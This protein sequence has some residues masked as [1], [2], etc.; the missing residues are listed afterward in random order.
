MAYLLTRA[1]LLQ[2]LRDMIKYVAASGAGSSAEL[3]RRLQYQVSQVWERMVSTA[4]GVGRATLSKTIAVADPDGYVPGDFVP[5]PSDFRR[6]EL[7]LIDGQEPDTR[8]PQEIERWAAQGNLGAIGGVLSF[9]LDGPGQDTTVSPPVPKDQR[10]RLFPAWQAGQSLVLHYVVQPPT[11]GDAADPLDDT[12]ELDLIHEPS[13]RYIVAR[14]CVDAVSREDQ[15]AYQR[16]KEER[17]DA[18]DEFTRALARRVGPPPPLSSY[19]HRPGW[20]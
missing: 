15:N 12:I 20:R 17:A 1:D 4:Q 6:Q 13:V 2:R 10:I 14:A 16:A 3:N 9:Y 8:T 19:R 5:L 18:E 11:L 7:L